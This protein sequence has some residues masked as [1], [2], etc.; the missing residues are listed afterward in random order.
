MTDRMRPSARRS[1]VQGSPD[2]RTPAE[3]TNV[4]GSPVGSSVGR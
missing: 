2:S 3:T 4:S 1:K